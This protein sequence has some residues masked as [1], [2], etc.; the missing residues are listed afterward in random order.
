MVQG[1]LSEA[2]LIT[3]D[4]DGDQEDGWA[5]PTGAVYSASAVRYRNTLHSPSFAE[6]GKGHPP[7]ADLIYWEE[8]SISLAH[9]FLLP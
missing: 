7:S 6:V 1:V 9:S 3:W 8:D 4:Y 2:E 5:G